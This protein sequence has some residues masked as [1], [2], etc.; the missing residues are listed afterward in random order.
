M[1]NVVVVENCMYVLGEVEFE[2]E[3]HK[4]KGRRYIWWSQLWISCCLVTK[5]CPLCSPMDCSMPGSPV[6]HYLPEFAQIHVHWVGDAIQP[7][8]PLP[9]PFPPAFNL[10]FPASGAFPMSQL[11][12]SGG[13]IIGV[14]ASASVLLM[15]QGWFPLGLTS[16]TSLQSKGLSKVFSST[17]I[18]KH[19]F[20]GV[21][22]S[23]WYSFHIHSW[24][25]EKP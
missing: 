5:L 19:Q 9:P 12:T 13:Q 6:L 1:K 24:L 7:S 15:N 23:L 18:R 2:F 8:H 17:R 3:L 4:D 22:P 25:L 11:F 10:S 14:S 16:L 21:Q 20:F